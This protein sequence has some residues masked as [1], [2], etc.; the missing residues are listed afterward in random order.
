M[1]R[2]AYRKR[3]LRISLLTGNLFILGTVVFFVVQASA[4]TAAPIGLAAP[5]TGGVANPLD[6]LS[7]ANIALNIAKTE[8]LPETTAISNQAESQAAD[9]A[10]ASTNNA[11]VAKPQVV[12]TALK[13]RAN[14]STYVTQ[15]NDT[16]ASIAAKFGITSN[17]ILWS[18][19]L[20][21]DTIS[22]NQKLV[23]PP[24][25]G[26]V[27]T[28]AKG[29]TPQSLART[30]SAS[31]AQIIAYNDAEISGIQVG[32]QIL[33]PNGTKPVAIAPP[34]VSYASSV[35]TQGASFPWGG[36]SP[37]YG[38]NGY[39]YGYC[40]WYVASLIS[41]PNNWGNASSWAFYAARSGWSVSTTP[42]VGAIA[43]TP[44][45]A[46]GEGHVA[47]VRAVSADGSQI[48]FSDMNGL[49]GWGRVGYSGWVSASTFVNY[50]SH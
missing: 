44:F 30:Y 24:V 38:S 42:T 33:I 31:E 19:E 21:S 17:S 43:Q 29:D 25:T 46:G 28:V 16:I 10:M 26:I 23:I 34:V 41:V 49:A 12:A 20:R 39:D 14:I 7:S 11:V 35:S 3:V 47:I 1:R 32:E 4:T 6:Q 36:N 22:A 15:P 50:I 27:Y 18:N 37:V 8:N 9:L 40:T 45:A 2:S 13:S 48:R 5:A